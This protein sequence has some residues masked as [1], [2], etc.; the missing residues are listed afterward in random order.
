MGVSFLFQ[1][2][3]AYFPQGN[4]DEFL[5]NDI[6]Q[7]IHKQNFPK[8]SDELKASIQKFM[9]SLQKRPAKV[10]SYFRAESVRYGG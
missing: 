6:T 9:R 3:S 8:D 5:N 2:T 7:N 4:P 10:K 1:I